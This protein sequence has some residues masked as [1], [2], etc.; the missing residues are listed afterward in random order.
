M[1][2][3][4]GRFMFQKYWHKDFSEKCQ[5]KGSKPISNMPYKVGSSDIS[6]L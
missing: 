3:Y 1:Q 2:G 5:T 6:E 4:V